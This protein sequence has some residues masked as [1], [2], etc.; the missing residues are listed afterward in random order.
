M[1]VIEVFELYPAAFAAAIFVLGLLVGSFLNVVIHRLPR[2]L[3]AEWRQQCQELLHPDAAPADQPSRY[4]LWWPPST[5]PHCGHR[6]RAWENIPVVSYLALRGRCSGCSAPISARYPLVELAT[7]LLSALVAWHF[8]PGWAAVAALGLTWAL[9]AL[10]VI[11]IDHQ[12][13]PDAITLPLVWA[14]LLLSVVGVSLSPD[15]LLTP[16]QSIIGAAAGY[17]SLWSV[18]HLFRLLTGKEGMGYGDFKLLA[19]F[20]AWLGWTA[21]PVV[22]LLS[23]LVGA[24]VGIGLIL[25]R[26][27]D[28]NIPIPFGPYLA[29]AGFLALLWREDIIALYLSW[30]GLN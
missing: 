22:I 8:G 18:Y 30:A 16:A 25:I 5:C 10:S 11:D 6:I 3:E 12:I 29:A 1:T 2:M 17:L 26:G 4:N 27:R 7:A 14:G 20:G 23:S 28:R 15:S 24:V 19:V 9:V 13:L 21:L